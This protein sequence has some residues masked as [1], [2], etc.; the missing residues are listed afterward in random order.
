ML[1]LM[2]L[3]SSQMVMGQRVV[4]NQRKQNVQR[5]R[6]LQTMPTKTE[7]EETKATVSPQQEEKIFDVVEE[8]PHFQGGH[9]ELMKWLGENTKYPQEAKQAQIQGRV[10]VSFVVEPDGSLSNAKIIRGV[11]E[12]LDQETVRLVNVMPKWVPGKQNGKLV[13]VKYNLPIQFKL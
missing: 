3:T 4:P 10:L 9:D 7:K 12:S 6:R 13:R 2:C 11:H 8:M 5:V 1:L